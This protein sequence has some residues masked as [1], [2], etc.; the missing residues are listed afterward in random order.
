MEDIQNNHVR[1]D[2]GRLFSE[3]IKQGNVIFS[4]G[5]A[6]NY[7]GIDSSTMRDLTDDLVREKL[8]KVVPR[9]SISCITCSKAARVID[10]DAGA[11]KCE[12][13]HKTVVPKEE[14]LTLHLDENGFLGYVQSL[15]K[16]HLDIITP[17][18]EVQGFLPFDRVGL[19]LVGRTRTGTF[20][21]EVLL[22]TRKVDIERACVLLGF[23]AF[24]KDNII[25]VVSGST[26]NDAAEMLYYKSNGAI[27]PFSLTSLFENPGL[28]QES[29][30]QLARGEE[31]ELIRLNSWM[32][33]QSQ[34]LRGV[35][36][37]EQ[38]R[39]I[40]NYNQTVVQGSKF[41]A[42]HGKDDEFEEA[43]S[44][45]LGSILPTTPLGHERRGTGLPDGVILLPYRNPYDVLFYDCKSTGSE[46]QPK[47]ERHLSKHDEDEFVRYT[48]LFRDPEVN[49]RL[50]GG[51]F[52]ANVFALQN[53]VN[54]AQ[55]LRSRIGPGVKVF[56]WPVD[57]LILL[58]SRI[59]TERMDY[60]PRIRQEHFAKLWGIGLTG[61]ERKRLQRDV[62]YDTFERL[63]AADT[64]S[65][66]LTKSL[67][68]IFFDNVR[69]S[70]P[71]S[72]SFMI[73]VRD[74]LRLAS[75]R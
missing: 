53:M 63:R 9:Q 6:R 71:A 22:A 61:V 46:A 45:L 54:R 68:D 21:V 17:S 15:L 49:A 31:A 35:P 24:T 44:S 38:Y 10:L 33:S 60:L 75:G 37:P 1:V 34:S 48:G 69:I 32:M 39:L 51:C 62:E 14:L 66:Y 40:L 7:L 42:T 73:Y 29:L 12:S 4:V 28:L 59:T 16:N 41:A 72:E 65:V 55:S 36:S 30:D 70:P 23:L 18:R 50:L 13:G 25:A 58:Y 2:L 8:G 3:Y 43:V 26:M 11:C 19:P 67:V 56:F 64:D 52:V 74:G 20:S 5:Q 57:S 27:R 47:S